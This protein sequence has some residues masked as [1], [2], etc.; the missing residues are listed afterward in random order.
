MNARII[1]KKI[2]SK[3]KIYLMDKSLIKKITNLLIK[4]KANSP[5]EINR[6]SLSMF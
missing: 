3:Y 6:K 4:N 2:N 1:N 5:K